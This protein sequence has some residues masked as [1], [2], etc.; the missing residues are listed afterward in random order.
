MQF[1]SNVDL[2]VITSSERADF[3]RCPK[4][5][6]WKWRMGLV[7]R[8]R[9]FGALD[10]GAWMHEGLAEWYQ[11]G[12]KRNGQLA[13]WF[14]IAAHHALNTAEEN[15][16]ATDTALEAAEPLVALGIEMANA[17]QTHYRREKIRIINTE[18]PLEFTFN[19]PNG[20]I[21]AAHKIK[22]DGLLQDE[23]GDFWLF[24][25]K[26]AKQIQTEHL[27]IDDQARPYGSM[28]EPALRKAGYL[29]RGARF[30]GILYNFLRK[31][32]PD[33]RPTNSKGQYLNKDLV[34]VSKRQPPPYFVRKKV[35]MTVAAKKITLSRVRD[36]TLAITEMTLAL[37]TG[38][39]HPDRLQKTQHRSCPKTC[40]FF[41]MC[42]A[43][44]GGANIRDFHRRM[45]R[46]EDP[47]L[48]H[49]DSTEDVAGFEIT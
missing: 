41:D 40:P 35:T 1:N 38:E 3:K 8:M 37:R 11:P 22:P 42:V 17:Y 16:Q 6:Y 5:W 2:P 4:R 26:T 33:Q 7:P 15:G 36:E 27:V 49:K 34:T 39:I 23:N 29:K 14:E 19:H 43:E 48:Y 24:E 18:I 30:R 21:V 47:Y 12:T 46:R 45:F 32:L 28:A 9:T 25:H 20:L 31:A 44:E 10:F 13:D